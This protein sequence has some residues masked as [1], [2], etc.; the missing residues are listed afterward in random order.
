LLDDDGREVTYRHY[1]DE[2]P[3]KSELVEI[4]SLLKLGHP[5]QMM[6][7]DF[8]TADDPDTCFDAIVNDPSLLQRPIY[9]D[10]H[11]AIIARPPQLVFDN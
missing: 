2:P 11:I 6:R 4:F 7:S 1:I 10:E 8:T 9:I 5:S 3:T